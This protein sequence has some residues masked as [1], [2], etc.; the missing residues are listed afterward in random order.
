MVGGGGNIAHYKCIIEY[1]LYGLMCC[2]VSVLLIFEVHNNEYKV[3]ALFHQN[4]GSSYF[5]VLQWTRPLPSPGTATTMGGDGGLED[6]CL[7]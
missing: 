2:N 5:A 1:F 3:A 4:I 7:Q 6:W